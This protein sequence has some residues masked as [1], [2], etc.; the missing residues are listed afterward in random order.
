M[1][2]AA[3]YV[4]HVSFDDLTPS[5]I[6]DQARSL[7]Q[8]NKP[9][10]FTNPFIHV[11]P[12]FNPLYVDHSKTYTNGD[13]SASSVSATTK[14]PHLALD[15]GYAAQSQQEV[16]TV[17]KSMFDFPSDPLRK[18]QSEMSPPSSSS[19]SL[20]RSS[21]AANKT[22]GKLPPPPAVSILRN[23][24][25]NNLD[26][27]FE[28]IFLDEMD[29]ELE[30]RMEHITEENT[31]Q[32]SGSSTGYTTSAFSNLHELE[33]KLMAEKKTEEKQQKKFHKKSIVDMT[34][35]ELT[36][37]EDKFASF[38]TPSNRL[39]QF[40]FSE[41][42]TLY[43]GSHHLKNSNGL[44]SGS[45]A[46]LYPSEPCVD[47]RA[48][49]LAKSSTNY[50][51]YVNDNQHA[52]S[53]RDSLRTVVCYIS[54]RRHTWSSVNWFVHGMCRDG[55][56]LVIISK[57]PVY[58][59]LIGKESTKKSQTGLKDYKLSTNSIEKNK[60]PKKKDEETIGLMIQ[61]VDALAKEKSRDILN[62]YTDKC[63]DKIMKISVELIK[64]NS[65]MDVISHATSLYKPDWQVISTVST[66]LQIKFNNGKVKLP[67]FMMR[68]Y[69]VPTMVI[70]YEFI[71][72]KLLGEAADESDVE[73]E[74]GSI[75]NTD[76]NLLE[77]LDLIVLKSLNNPFKSR[78]SENA[79]IDADE[80][81]DEEGNDEDEDSGSIDAY[82]PRDPTTVKKM[83]NFERLGYIRPTPSRSTGSSMRVLSHTSSG[84]S[85]RRSSRVQ[86]TDEYH[87][88]MYKVKSLLD[89]D[90]SSGAPMRKTKSMGHASV[91]SMNSSTARPKSLSPKVSSKSLDGALMNG[92]KE[93][94]KKKSGKLGGFFKK[95]GFGKH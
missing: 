66:N 19:T 8:R 18:T 75:H 20:T 84:K 95:L 85:S 37:L 29:R 3:T 33:D 10:S 72:P 62:Y 34:D 41:Q 15:F 40:D 30:K 74:R 59:S 89:D 14:R 71:D 78:N 46:S 1:S 65:T 28:E 12:Q 21:T 11:P 90:H 87:P 50:D 73:T 77:R 47:H 2:Q 7:K 27:D 43:I 26:E 5:L 56:H 82:F 24:H 9:I 53:P 91:T 44:N 58:D 76:T 86:F 54:G 69:S 49:S 94:A 25:I 45:R 38:S 4:N 92:K 93:K 48:L 52:D 51:S 42:N 23:K 6:D 70:P 67:F 57:L 13:D 61:S 31:Q 16:T 22:Q 17:Y 64:E 39:E 63:K 55:D 88:G 80:D 68:H 83:E 36:Q 79:S 32:N 35:E 60:A 81:E